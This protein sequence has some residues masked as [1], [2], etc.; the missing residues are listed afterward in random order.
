MALVFPCLLLLALFVF[1]LLGL[2]LFVL[3]VV[4]AK[5]LL[6]LDVVCFVRFRLWFV[7]SFAGVGSLEG[8][9]ARE[10]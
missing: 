1:V 6:A 7:S 3:A 8:K 5:G 4:R 10:P 9:A 2:R